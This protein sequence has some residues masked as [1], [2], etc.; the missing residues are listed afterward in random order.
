MSSSTKTVSV[1]DPLVRIGHWTLV[2]AFFTAYFTEEDFLTQHTWA[3]YVVG[4]VVLIRIIWGFIGSK[5]AKFNDFIYSPSAIFT[6]LNGLISRKPQHYL[7]HNPAGGLMVFALLLS[8]SATTYTGIALYA[9]EKNAGPLAGIVANNDKTMP[10]ASIISTAYADEV[11]DD[12]KNE[13][14]NF[15]VNEADEEFWEGLHEFFVNFT[16]LLIA[17]HIGGVLISSYVDKENLIKAMVTGRKE[18][19]PKEIL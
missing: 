2:I 8:L 1:W 15:S 11:G 5:H 17:L 3:G 9:V 18:V 12:D 10:K 13:Q 14:G 16:L 4:T 19:P 7:G 6:Y